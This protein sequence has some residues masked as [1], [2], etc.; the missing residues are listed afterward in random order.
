MK[1]QIAEQLFLGDFNAHYESWLGS[2]RTAHAGRTNL[3]FAHTH[4]LTLLVL[5]PTRIPVILSQAPSL[6]DLLLM[7]HPAQ[8]SVSVA[9]PLGSFGYYLVATTVPLVGTPIDQSPRSRLL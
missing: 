3:A 4:N 6:L 9:A 7:S 1:F 8:Y 5:Q 2:S